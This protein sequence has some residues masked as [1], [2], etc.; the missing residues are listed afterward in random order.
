MR[1]LSAGELTA[2]RHVVYLYL[3]TE[4]LRLN[5]ADERAMNLRFG[6]VPDFVRRAPSVTQRAVIMPMME[7][8]FG[9][10]LRGV[11]GFYYDIRRD[12]RRT[13]AQAAGLSDYPESETPGGWNLNVTRGFLKPYHDG[14]GR[15]MGL[16]VFPSAASRFPVLLSS[17]GL[18]FGEEAIQPLQIQRSLAA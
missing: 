13:L 6:Y 4:C 5:E 3:L 14:R 17:A 11:A 8:A 12:T 18:P 16:Y 7:Q 1:E 2:R 10:D 15:I 9:F